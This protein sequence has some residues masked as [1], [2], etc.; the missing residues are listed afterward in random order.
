MVKNHPQKGQRVSFLHHGATLD[1]RWIKLTEP[2]PW[3]VYNL[4]STRVELLPLLSEEIKRLKS[5]SQWTSMTQLKGIYKETKHDWIA[6]YRDQSSSLLTQK[7]MVPFNL[8]HWSW[9]Q[10]WSTLK[11][12]TSHPLR[13]TRGA[14]GIMAGPMKHIWTLSHAIAIKIDLGEN[15]RDLCN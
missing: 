5:Q 1:L 2:C 8:H 4:R 7:F 11:A 10:N 13:E 14:F 12:N 6:V 3:E 15:F 9:Q